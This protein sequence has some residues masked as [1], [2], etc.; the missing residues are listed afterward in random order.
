MDTMP[1]VGV[2]TRWIT[3]MGVICPVIYH[4]CFPLWLDGWTVFSPKGGGALDHHHSPPANATK[5]N[6]IDTTV[7]EGM[8]TVDCD[9]RSTSRALVGGN[10][11]VRDIAAG[12][13][14]G[15]W[16]AEA[17]AESGGCRLG[18]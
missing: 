16:A 17:E 12:H 2:S 7:E 8:S 11:S 13:S 4:R 1:E 6:P 18:R 5:P 9:A 15:R 14:G 3:C 10:G